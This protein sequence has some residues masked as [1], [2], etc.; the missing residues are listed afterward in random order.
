MRAQ[1]LLFST[2]V[3]VPI[4]V[5]ITSDDSYFK[6]NLDYINLYNLIRLEASSA[7]VHLPVRIRAA[8]EPYRVA[9]ECFFQH[10]RSRVERP[11]RRAR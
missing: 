6:F 10:Y 2:T 1:R 7:E 11:R 4:G 8:A 3:P 5:D 9:S